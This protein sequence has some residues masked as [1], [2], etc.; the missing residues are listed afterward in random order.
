MEQVNNV[1][2]VKVFNQLYNKYFSHKKNN[3]A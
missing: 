2:G 1:F 3:D